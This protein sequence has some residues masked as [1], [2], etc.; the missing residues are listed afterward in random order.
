MNLLRSWFL[1]NKKS[2]F[3][4]NLLLSKNLSQTHLGSIIQDFPLLVEPSAFLF[5]GFLFLNIL[6]LYGSA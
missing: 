3:K 2:S 5:G 6:E 4:N 1:I